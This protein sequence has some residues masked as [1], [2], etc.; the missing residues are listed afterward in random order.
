MGEHFG[1]NGKDLS[2]GEHGWGHPVCLCAMKRLMFAYVSELVFVD[3][4]ETMCAHVFCFARGS[5][6]LQVLQ[7]SFYPLSLNTIGGLTKHML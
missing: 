2:Q 1:V 7:P 3:F 5:L 4:V 6:S